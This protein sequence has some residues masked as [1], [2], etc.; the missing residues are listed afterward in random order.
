MRSVAA[1]GIVVPA[2]RVL[3]RVTGAGC[4]FASVFVRGA[5]KA[6]VFETGVVFEPEAGPGAAAKFWEAG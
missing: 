5:L 3:S 2:P 4:G 1:A 6:G